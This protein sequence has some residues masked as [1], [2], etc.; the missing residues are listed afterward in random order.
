MVALHVF[1]FFMRTHVTRCLATWLSNFAMSHLFLWGNTCKSD[2]ERIH[3]KQERWRT[4]PPPPPPGG[5]IHSKSP[6]KIF[7]TTRVFPS[8][9]T[10]EIQ[11][12]IVASWN[13]WKDFIRM[14]RCQAALSPFTQKGSGSKPFRSYG[15]WCRLRSK[16]EVGS[17]HINCLKLAEMNNKV[18]K[19]T[20]YKLMFTKMA[21]E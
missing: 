12:A 14:T 8:L 15:F 20:R 16:E 4:P 1:A 3:R 19:C 11:A 6:R 17:G 21:R 2:Q 9:G 13:I 7:T 5:M 10:L 18:I